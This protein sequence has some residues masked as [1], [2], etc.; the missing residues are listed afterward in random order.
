MDLKNIHRFLEQECPHDYRINEIISF[1]YPHRHVKINATV[2]KSPEVPI[3]QVYSVLLRSV[4][5]GYDTNEKLTKFLGLEQ[6]DFLLRE[7]FFLREKG[8]VDLVSD[9][10]LVGS[11]G[12]KYIEDNSFL[13]VIEEEEFE[14]LV[15]GITGEILEKVFLTHN[16]QSKKVKPEICYEIKDPALIAD[17]SIYLA[18]VYNKQNKGQSVL[19]DYD[20]SKILFDKLEYQDY[21]LIEYTPIKAA[22]N[23]PYIQVR[24][25]DDDCTLNRKLTRILSLKYPGII[26]ELSES[27]RGL[28][29]DSELADQFNFEPIQI[30]PK[31]KLVNKNRTMTVWETRDFIDVA[32][33]TVKKKILIESPWVKAATNNYI[34][35]IA[36]LIANKKMVYILYG[37]EHNDNHDEIVLNR[38]K[39][40][41]K[42]HPNNLY[43]VHLPSHFKQMGHNTLSGTHR[44]LIIK[45]NDYFI[46]GSFNYLSFNKRE[47]DRVANEESV[48]I[49]E[50]VEDKWTQ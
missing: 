38:L 21:I 34:E 25:A 4:G 5:A 19:V 40:L 46:L 33:N 14:F 49:T 28:A 8:Y 20:R 35:K 44:K 29:S 26:Y 22:T 48:L 50:N 30:P 42:Q 1:A 36:D 32:L 23:E 15:D 9:T 10:W 41:N 37:I 24:S 27:N 31:N 13:K 17:K 39:N 47:G 3:Q 18:E 6:N 12:V 16:N 2:S 45:D 11:L 43:L 7:L